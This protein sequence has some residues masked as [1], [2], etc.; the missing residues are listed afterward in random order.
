M[1]LSNITLPE[2]CHK[3]RLD[4]KRSPT[5]HSDSLILPGFQMSKANTSSRTK[6]K[7][8]SVISA[9]L[10][11]GHKKSRSKA[12]MQSLNLFNVARLQE[13]YNLIHLGTPLTFM[14]EEAEHKHLMTRAMKKFKKKNKQAYLAY[15]GGSRSPESKNAFHKK[16]MSIDMNTLF[17]SDLIESNGT[18]EN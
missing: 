16:S 4:T 17:H 9:N 5:L 18:K 13:Q 11:K 2:G 3:H 6:D 8:S 14:K 7:G 10:L 1:Q 12:R 15:K